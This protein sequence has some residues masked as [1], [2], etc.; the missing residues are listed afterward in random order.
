MLNLTVNISCWLNHRQDSRNSKDAVKEI[1]THLRS[2]VWRRTTVPQC[3]EGFP[4]L[5]CNPLIHAV[6]Q[7]MNN[8]LPTTP[9][10]LNFHAELKAVSRW[11]WLGGR[12]YLAMKESLDSRRKIAAEETLKSWKKLEAEFL[13]NEIYSPGLSFLCFGD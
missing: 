7:Y 3:G 5:L 2:L 6:E 1:Q 10:E 13:L 11:R 8:H 12:L 4:L 9:K